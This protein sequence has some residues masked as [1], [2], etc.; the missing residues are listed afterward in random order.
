MDDPLFGLTIYDTTNPSD[1]VGS[2]SP[3]LD[4]NSDSVASNVDGSE[5]TVVQGNEDVSEDCFPCLPSMPEDHHK[6]KMRMSEVTSGDVK[7][8]RKGGPSNSYGPESKELDQ[9][10]M[11]TKHHIALPK[12][13]WLMRLF[14][15][16]LFDMSIAIGYLFNS[17]DSSVQSYLGSRLFVSKILD[18]G[19]GVFKAYFAKDV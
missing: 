16:N 13:F 6:H 5:A 17:K 7:D 10:P 2:G 18:C 1:G 12:H 4:K 9:P 3:M 19:C 14:Q 11:P 15:S 8:G